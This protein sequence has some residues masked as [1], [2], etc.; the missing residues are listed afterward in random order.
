MGEML[1]FGFPLRPYRQFNGD[2]D[3][4]EAGAACIPIEPAMPPWPDAP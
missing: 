2:T 4:G 1:L 3:L